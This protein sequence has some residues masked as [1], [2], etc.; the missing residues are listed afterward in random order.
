LADALRKG[1][2]VYG[3]DIADNRLEIFSKRHFG[4]ITST[5]YIWIRFWSMSQIRYRT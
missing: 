5:L 2:E 1:W 4:I 3:L